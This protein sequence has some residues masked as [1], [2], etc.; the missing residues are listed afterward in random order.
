MVQ[1]QSAKGWRYDPVPV[2]GQV[3]INFDPT[4]LF[5]IREKDAR[6]HKYPC[7]H[8]FWVGINFG[9]DLIRSRAKVEYQEALQISLHY[10]FVKSFNDLLAA[11][12]L[13]KSGYPF[14]SWPLIRGGV[15]AAE[16][17]EY[18]YHHPEDTRKWINKEERF[19]SLAWLR[20]ELPKSDFRKNFYN[21]VNDSTSIHVNLRA[22]DAFS[23]IR[24]EEKGVRYLSVGPNPF[25]MEEPNPI[26]VV[27][28]IISY[29]VRV[30]W[31]SDPRVVDSTWVA[32][33]HSFDAEADFP[34][35]EPWNDTEKMK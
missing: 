11:V 23:T 28:A 24:S 20:R 27:S 22:I 5:D 29:P 2:A 30:L 4:Q 13:S 9:R 21:T 26:G 18:L 35:G 12:S 25:P 15:E 6:R 3:G 17:M 34:F 1:G 7:E 31:Q 33:F 8:K 14:Q 19:D 10:L 16:L 32:T